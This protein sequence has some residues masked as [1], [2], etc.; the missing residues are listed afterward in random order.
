MSLRSVLVSRY[1]PELA[2][3]MR[4]LENLRKKRLRLEASITFLT[5]CRDSNVIPTCVRITPRHDIA[6]SGDILRNASVRLL[7]QLIRN[8]HQDLISVQ[9]ELYKVH[10]ECSAVMSGSDFDT[11]DRVTSQQASRLGEVIATRHDHKWSRLMLRTSALKGSGTLEANQKDEVINLSN[12]V[13]DDVTKKVLTKGLNFA[14]TPKRIPYETVISNVEETIIRNKVPTEDADN[15]RQDVAIVLRKS[16]VPKSNITEEER[17]ALKNLKENPDMLILR[18]DKGNATVVMNADDYDSKIYA[19]LDNRMVYKPV[20]YNP[21][22]RVTRRIRAV[23]RDN[24]KLFTEDVFEGLYRPKIVQ[25]PKLYGTPKVHK[26]NVPLRPIVSQIDSPSY[27][28]AKHVAKIMR[29]LAGDT[30]SYVKDSRH[31]VNI[32]SNIRL[33]PDDI[34]VSFDV[35]SL[36]TN[37]PVKECL[38]VIRN[39]LSKNNIPEGYMVLLRNCLEGAYLLYRGQ[40]YLQIDGVAMGSPVAPIMANIWMEHIETLIDYHLHDVKIWRRYVDDVFCIL[41]GGQPEVE[42]FLRHLNALHS[43]IKFTYELQAN[44]TLPFLDVKVMAQADGTLKHTVYRKPTHTD[45]YLNASSHH[46]PKHLRSVETSLVNRARALCDPEFLDEELSHVDKI[47]RRNGYRGNV[48]GKLPKQ[49]YRV[50]RSD[51]ARQ[52]AYLPYIKGVTDK[53]GCILRKFSINTVFTPFTKMSQQIGT[54]KDVIPYQSP[55]VYKVECSCGSSYIGQTKRTIAERVKEHIAAVKNRQVEKSAIA[56][57][58]LLSGPNHWIELHAPKI[59]STERHYYPRIVREAVE[60]KKHK[61]FNRESGFKLSS[62]WNPVINK[63]KH[64][65]KSQSVVTDTVSVVCRVPNNFYN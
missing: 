12:T 49:R 47:L 63:W 19:L 45:K 53:I 8:G 42:Q 33:E 46:H 58:L 3:K 31:F 20:T 35:E 28:L 22:A 43:K 56:E 24:E 23:I 48:R 10:S 38:E 15:L 7:K 16:R 25:P 54:P 65:A 44:N 26:T 40:Y 4:H 61:N 5:K 21:T 55:G 62:V 50:K 36:F 11:C 30:T 59:L 41:R 64:R 1:G 29:P 57:H 27:H 60:I 34:M 9:R 2:N 13:L 39:K 18:A 52:P 32:L 17:L 37:V 51:V 14:T 6:H